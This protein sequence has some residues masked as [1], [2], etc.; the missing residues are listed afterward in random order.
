[1]IPEHIKRE[2]LIEEDYIIYSPTIGSFAWAILKAREELEQEGYA[3]KIE[4]SKKDIKKKLQIEASK[5]G[6][7][8]RLQ[9]QAV[10]ER[11]LIEANEGILL[12]VC[13]EP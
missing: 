10:N 1:V 2:P 3:T 6:I 12:A 8:K 4:G 7:K 11:E 9:I 13:R 5:R